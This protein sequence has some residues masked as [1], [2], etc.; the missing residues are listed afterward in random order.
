MVFV[1]EGAVEEENAVRQRCGEI[2]FGWIENSFA[3]G[4]KAAQSNADGKA[5]VIG[6]GL[7]I[8]F[9][10]MLR[11]RCSLYSIHSE[12]CPLLSMP[13]RRRAGLFELY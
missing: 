11:Q 6:W 3:I 9:F 5:D 13:P 8:E 12:L 7:G 4:S 10:D 1:S 2:V